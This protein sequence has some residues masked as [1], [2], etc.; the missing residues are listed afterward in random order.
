MMSVVLLDSQGGN[1]GALLANLRLRN[2]GRT[3]QISETT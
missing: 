2:V 1:S 3:L